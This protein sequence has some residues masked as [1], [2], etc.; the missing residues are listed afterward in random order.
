MMQLTGER[1]QVVAAVAVQEQ[2]LLDALPA[3]GVGQI[4]EDGEHGRRRQATSYGAG[5]LQV[6]GVDAERQGRE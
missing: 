4:G 6:I 3:Q 2:Q 5:D 1:F